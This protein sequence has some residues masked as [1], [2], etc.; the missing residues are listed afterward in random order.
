MK[1][2]LFAVMLLLSAFFACRKSDID[3]VQAISLSVQ[4]GYS[5]EDSALGLSK[6]NVL[7]KITNLIS[8]QENTA[9]TNGSGIAVF[10]SIAPGNYTVSASR[11]YTEEEFRSLTNV[12]VTSNVP[13]NATETQ[14]LNMN[15]NIRL[16]LQGGKIGDLVFKQIYY[17]G[18]DTKTGALY[19]DQFVEIYN[20]SNETI[21]LDS[22]FLG[23]TICNNKA[24]STGAV[25]FDWSKV[26]GMSAIG[27]PNKDNLYFRY[28]FMIP[29][30]GK[31]HPL[32]P[33][34]S[35]VVAQTAMNHA[36]PYDGNDGEIIGIT[37][38]A[39]TI[40]LSHADFEVNLVEDLRE[41]YTGTGTFQPWKYDVDNPL[42]DN[43]KAFIY[44]GKD[45][46]MDNNSR[47]DFIMFKAAGVDMS[48]LPKF[49]A[50]SGGG[51][52]GLQVPLTVSIIDAVELVTPLETDRTPKRLPVGLDASGNF[53]AGARYSSQSLIRKT[54]KTVEGRRILQDTNS[55]ANDFET[56][57]KADPS[58]SDASFEK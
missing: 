19:R 51:D 28:L 37:N 2:Q 20:N 52:Y 31:E 11:N 14:A 36:N 30:T 44:S 25:P 22:L 48:N 5:P 41:A 33:G 21:Y 18:S 13:Y 7:V 35:I 9:S 53:V 29:G 50:P 54:V 15:T 6:E 40:D 23:S 34:K 16:Q 55:S 10:A 38:P 56:K 45:W 57:T 43:V 49:L 1:K 24:V 32:E 42:V 4:V 58:K 27:D 3:T 46:V 39:L 47:D 12:F 8:G 17:A 26:S